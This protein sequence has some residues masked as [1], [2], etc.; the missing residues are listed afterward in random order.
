ALPTP[1]LPMHIRQSHD[2]SEIEAS[3]PRFKPDDLD[4]TLDEN[5]LTIRGTRHEDEVMRGAYVRRERNAHSVYRQVGL[6]AEVK[7]DEITAGFDNGVLTVIVPRAQRAQPKR[8][9]VIATVE[10]PKLIESGADAPVA[11]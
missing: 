6:P 2:A 4:I 8:I 11:V 7:T 1:P 5:V 9:P 10:H 3:V